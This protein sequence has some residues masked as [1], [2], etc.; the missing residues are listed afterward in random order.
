MIN[1]ITIVVNTLCNE[2]L[3][4]KYIKKITNTIYTEA[5][6]KKLFYYNVS[7]NVD[8]LESTKIIRN[9]IERKYHHSFHIFW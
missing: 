4:I 5:Y 2:F 1:T 3:Y 8:L 7:P 9:D 6:E